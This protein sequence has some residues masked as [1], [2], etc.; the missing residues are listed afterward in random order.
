MNLKKLL[1]NS[2]KLIHDSFISMSDDYAYFIATSDD[3]KLSDLK[4]HTAWSLFVTQNLTKILTLSVCES[5]KVYHCL[6]RED[7][8]KQGI[9]IGDFVP[10]EDET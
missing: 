5:L 2:E 9:D 10:S 3:L 7:L 6:L 8:L 4:Q 1:L